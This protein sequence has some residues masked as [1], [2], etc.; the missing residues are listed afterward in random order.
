MSEVA[1]E[2]KGYKLVNSCEYA[3]PGC[4][5]IVI[6]IIAKKYNTSRQAKILYGNNDCF[7]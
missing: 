6:I 1:R 2:T 3:P 7:G 5:V 4:H